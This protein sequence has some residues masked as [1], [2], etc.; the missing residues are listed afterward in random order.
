LT[1]YG[2]PYYN[3]SGR[4]YPNVSTVGLNI[5]LYI[6][7]QPSFVDSMSAF[8]PIFASTINLINKKRLATGKSTVGFIN[9]TLYKNPNAFTNI[10]YLAAVAY[11]FINRTDYRQKQSRV[12]RQ[13]LQCYKGVGSSYGF[14]HSKVLEAFGRLHGLAISSQ[15][16]GE[17]RV[18]STLVGSASSLT[19]LGTRKTKLRSTQGL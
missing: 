7:G 10:S 11:T 5:L 4:G 13:W 3:Q 19:S 1:L 9:L 2:T 14:R 16:L 18:I 17:L 6:D 12:Q 15:G 8:A